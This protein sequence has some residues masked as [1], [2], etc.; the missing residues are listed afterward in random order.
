MRV[1]IDEVLIYKSPPS[2]L[3]YIWYNKHCSNQEK[4]Q[5]KAKRTRTFSKRKKNRG[6]IRCHKRES[7][8]RQPV[9]PAV[10]ILSLSG[11]TEH[12]SRPLVTI[13]MKNVIQHEIDL[14]VFVDR[15]IYVYCSL[16]SAKNIGFS[17][18]GHFLNVNK[19]KAH[20]G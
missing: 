13:I 1:K 10:F 12:T 7:T 6:R 18:L 14:T 17:I 15:Y 5:T 3:Y 4:P 8:L 9:T 11:K 16:N 19:D 2:L 20:T